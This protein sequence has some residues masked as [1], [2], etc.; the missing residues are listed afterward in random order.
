MENAILNKLTEVLVNILTA[1][2][3]LINPKRYEIGM[4][5]CIGPI[6]GNHLKVAENQAFEIRRK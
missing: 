5:P 6:N 3:K 2:T 4:V 1:D